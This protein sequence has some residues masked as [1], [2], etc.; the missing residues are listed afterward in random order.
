MT[1]KAKHRAQHR[2]QDAM[3]RMQ[4]KKP[5]LEKNSLH[6]FLMKVTEIPS[7]VYSQVCVKLSLQRDL[8]LMTLEC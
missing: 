7:E 8:I 5:D 2:A 6:V 4:E 3:F 1:N